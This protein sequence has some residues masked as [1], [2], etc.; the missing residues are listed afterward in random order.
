MSFADGHVHILFYGVF[1]RFAL[2]F[3]RAQANNHDL[4]DDH[5]K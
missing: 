2:A 3:R 5:Q 4:S 1:A